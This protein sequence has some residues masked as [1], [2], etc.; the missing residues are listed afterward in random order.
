M[1]STT[2]TSIDNRLEDSQNISAEAKKS[3]EPESVSLAD[4]GPNMNGKQVGLGLYTSINNSLE[5]PRR[6]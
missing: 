1:C 2:P 5:C 4:R 3:T 6:A